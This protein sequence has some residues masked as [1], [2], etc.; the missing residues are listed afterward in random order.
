MSEMNT[1]A[2]YKLSYV[3]SGTLN[4]SSIF[5][6]NEAAQGVRQRVQSDCLTP[7]FQII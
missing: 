7:D 1:K 6:L 3:L 5:T 2:M 4:E